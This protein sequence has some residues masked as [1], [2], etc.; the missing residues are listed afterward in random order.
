MKSR[1]SGRDFEVDKEIWV[2]FPTFESTAIFLHLVRTYVF[3]H[4]GGLSVVEARQNVVPSP[5]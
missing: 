4:F 5:K 2:R 3:G 1:E